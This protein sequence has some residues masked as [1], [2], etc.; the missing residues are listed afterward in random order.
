MADLGDVEG[1]SRNGEEDQ[2]YAFQL[3]DGVYKRKE[4]IIS[5]NGS[6]SM[7]ANLDLRGNKIMSLADPA[8][9]Q[10]A[11]TKGYVHSQILDS[12]IFVHQATASIRR[13]YTPPQELELD[14]KEEH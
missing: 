13:S 10:E 6:T 5:S 7:Q 12:R 11:A 9:P 8:E 2:L 1:F 3:A 4:G 14:S